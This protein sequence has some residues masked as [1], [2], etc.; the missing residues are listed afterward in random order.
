MTITQMPT[1]T[2]VQRAN[3]N[4]RRQNQLL[5]GIGSWL[6]T[7]GGGADTMSVMVLDLPRQP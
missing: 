4:T 1:Q 5:S 7:V 2:T 3:T 6:S